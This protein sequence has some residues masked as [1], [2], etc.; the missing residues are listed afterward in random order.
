MVLGNGG[1]PYFGGG[2]ESWG[3]GGGDDADGGDGGGDGGDDDGGDD[4]MEGEEEEVA[5]GGGVGDDAKAKAKTKQLEKVPDGSRQERHEPEHCRW[6]TNEG[7]KDR[8]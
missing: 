7:S 5:G 4:M 6:L 1:V 8:G 3:E 2:C